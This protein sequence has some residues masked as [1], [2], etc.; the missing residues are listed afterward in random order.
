MKIEMGESLFYSWLR[1]VKGCQTVQT[2]WKPSTCWD[3]PEYNKKMARLRDV[4]VNIIKHAHA[5]GSGIRSLLPLKDGKNK[6]TLDQLKTYE[7]EKRIRILDNMILQIVKQAE[8]DVI[9]ASFNPG[10]ENKKNN[11]AVQYYTIDVAFHTG[12]LGYSKN[13]NVIT[14]LRK[15]IKTAFCI[16]LY[17]GARTADLYF[18]TPIIRKSRIDENS[19]ENIITKHIYPNRHNLNDSAQETNI[20]DIFSSSGFNF[21]FH[22]LCGIQFRYEVIMPMILLSQ[23]IN[24]TSELFLRSLLLLD[25]SNFQQNSAISKEQIKLKLI[26]IYQNEIQLGLTS[27]ASIANFIFIPILKSGTL[28]KEEIEN[29][30]QDSDLNRDFTASSNPILSQE[31][32]KRRYYAKPFLLKDEVNTEYYFSNNWNKGKLSKIISWYVDYID[33]FLNNI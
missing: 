30:K 24:D 16:F 9:G 7:E 23:S 11:I 6:I 21:K 4:Y 28:S 5:P 18:A 3:I 15:L 20:Y 2:N 10:K 33:K 25:I 14:V 12:G 17:F 1:H 27:I 31:Y 29:F 8:C 19:D 32:I 26:E 13:G 22:L